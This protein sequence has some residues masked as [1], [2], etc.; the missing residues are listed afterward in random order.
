MLFDFLRPRFELAP[1]PLDLSTWR[2]WTYEH[3][4]IMAAAPERAFA[5][6]LG[7]DPEHGERWFPDFASRTWLSGPPHGPGSRREYRLR[8][9]TLIEEFDVWEPNRR[10]AFWVSRSSWPLHARFREIWDLSPHGSFTRV[11]W[12]IAYA[13]HRRLSWAAPVAHRMFG[14]TFAKAVV[15]LEQLSTGVDG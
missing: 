14:G 13:P 8:Y 10:F 7:E 1:A 5:I 9:L 15:N 6:L 12:T 2:P 11:R 3:D 4:F